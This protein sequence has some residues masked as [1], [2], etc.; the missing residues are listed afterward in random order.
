VSTAATTAGASTAGR[1]AGKWPHALAAA[2]VL[3]L[4]QASKLLVLRE[5]ELGRPLVVVPGYFRLELWMNP[6]GV[7]GLGQEVGQ[8]ARLVL[9]IVLP[10]AIT[11]VALWHAWQ[12]PASAR[13]RQLAIAL[14]VGGA[15]GNLIDRLRLGQVVDFFVLHVGEHA[16]PA[17]NVADSA[18]CVG[19]VLLMAC[20]MLE[21]EP[22][23]PRGD[24]R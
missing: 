20:V 24:G 12:A 5:L 21:R 15:I 3:G 14:V 1:W 19:V 22:E 10:V 17:F 13:W 2:L 18:I 4:D 7:W 6:G 16:W 9:F 8:I 23:A 11:I